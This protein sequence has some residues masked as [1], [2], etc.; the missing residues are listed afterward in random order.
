MS[1]IVLWDCWSDVTVFSVHAP[2]DNQIG[3]FYMKLEHVFGQ[4][5][6]YHMKILL[7]CINAKVGREDTFQPA[8]RN[9][10]LHEI[11]NDDGINS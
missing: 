3:H 8:V 9:E 2:T 6:E 4:F 1:Y 10:S 11:S 7:G 5:L